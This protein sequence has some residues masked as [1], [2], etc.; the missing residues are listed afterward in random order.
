MQKFVV[1][2]LLVASLGIFSTASADL[3]PFVHQDNT[4]NACDPHNVLCDFF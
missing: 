1:S 3:S 2:T 4:S